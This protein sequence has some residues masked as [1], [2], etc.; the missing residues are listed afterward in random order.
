M[1]L[2]LGINFKKRC[3]RQSLVDII[4]SHDTVIVPA[5]EEKDEICPYTLKAAVLQTLS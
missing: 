2:A 5:T 1:N 4:L 3:N